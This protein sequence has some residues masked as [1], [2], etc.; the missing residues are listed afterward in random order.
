MADLSNL[1]QDLMRCTTVQT[2]AVIVFFVKL[3]LRDLRRRQDICQGQ[4]VEAFK[5]RNDLSMRN[6]QIVDSWL[7]EAI[8]R[9]E[10]S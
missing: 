4:R 8:D 7:A 9:K 2:E 3:K 10:F 6:L 5:Q 1:P